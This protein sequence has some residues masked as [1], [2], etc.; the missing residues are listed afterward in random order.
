MFDEAAIPTDQRPEIL[1]QA[2]ERMRDHGVVHTVVATLITSGVVLDTEVQ[3]VLTYR[4]QI[5]GAYRGALRHIAGSDP[6][7][8]TSK[9][10]DWLA[11]RR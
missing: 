8:D 2:R 4:T 7:Y 10:A 5:V 11:N 6:G 3:A 1:R 9:W